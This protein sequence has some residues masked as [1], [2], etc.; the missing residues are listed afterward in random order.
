MENTKIC[1]EY[2]KHMHT[3]LKRHT[4]NQKQH[5]GSALVHH[6]YKITINNKHTLQLVLLNHIHTSIYAIDRDRQ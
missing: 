3:Q 2:S 1:D 5:Q 6:Q 4:Y